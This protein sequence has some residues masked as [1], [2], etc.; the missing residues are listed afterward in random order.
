LA[1]PWRKRSDLAALSVLVCL[2][3]AATGGPY[4][5][6]AAKRWA[7]TALWGP[8]PIPATAPALI[9]SW[10]GAGGAMLSF[11]ANGQFHATDMPSSM[12]TNPQ[13]SMPAACTSGGRWSISPA[14]EAGPGEPPEVDLDI[15][16]WCIGGFGF[17]LQMERVSS[18]L[19]LYFY[20]GDPDDD[21]EFVFKKL[22]NY[23]VSV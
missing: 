6:T 5:W 21:N 22:R 11:T 23:E 10:E 14:G 1:W 2:A 15:G 16:P 7:N 18:R 4:L 3:A 8:D 19:E 13:W 17:P 12:T 20:I 9:G